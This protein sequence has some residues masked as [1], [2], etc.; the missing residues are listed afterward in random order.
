MYSSY[1]KILF[2][3]KHIFDIFK[4]LEVKESPGFCWIWMGWYTLF[5]LEI[6]CQYF[7]QLDK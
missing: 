4:K 6:L 3:F 2:P 7:A 5:M 1:S